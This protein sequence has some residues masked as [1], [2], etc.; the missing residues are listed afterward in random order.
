MKSLTA[1]C[2]FALLAGSVFAQ[3]NSLLGHVPGRLPVRFREGVSPA[4]ATNVPPPAPV[5]C[6]GATCGTGVH[7]S[8]AANAGESCFRARPE[9]EIAEPDRL[10]R[11]ADITPDDPISTSSPLATLIPDTGVNGVHSDPACKLIADWN[12]CAKC[13][14]ISDVDAHR[15]LIEATTAALSNAAGQ[16][17]MRPG[18]RVVRLW[19]R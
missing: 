1:L 4:E 11:P 12:T 3:S 5:R 17:G 18:M 7:I 15:T 8:L 16:G 14:N 13:S 6:N 10:V 9:V 19:F 2:L